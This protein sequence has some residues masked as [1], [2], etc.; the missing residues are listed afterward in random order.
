MSTIH[1]HDHHHPRYRWRTHMDDDDDALINGGVDECFPCMLC[2]SG[3][4][5]GNQEN[6]GRRVLPL[7][8]FLRK[9]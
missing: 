6:R 8:F 4:A 1:Q 7:L 2:G 3:Y 5:Y 9:K